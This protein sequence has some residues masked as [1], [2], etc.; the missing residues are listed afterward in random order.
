MKTILTLLLLTIFAA[1]AAGQPDDKVAKTPRLNYDWQPGFVSITELTAAP[2]IGLT[3]EPY[4]KY[5]FGISTVAGY[6]FTRNIKAGL[7]AG[8]NFHNGGTLFPVFV[9]ARYSFSAQ[10]FVPFI[11]A[12]GGVA[13]DFPLPNTNLFINPSVGIKW[14]AVNKLSLFFA[15]GV[16]TMVGPGD[17]L[18]DSFISLKLGLELK[19]K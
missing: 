3:N 5:Y 4:A 18:R 9:D 11:A 2:G 13:L 19:G 12:S 10:E 7:G 1:S 14:I 15:A 8:V 16:M 17:A 6:Q